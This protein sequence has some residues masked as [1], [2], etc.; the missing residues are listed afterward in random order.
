R[1]SNNYPVHHQH[2]ITFKLTEAILNKPS[3][4]F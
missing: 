1:N 3:I 4:P 2:I